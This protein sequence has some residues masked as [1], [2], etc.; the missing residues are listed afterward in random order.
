MAREAAR[1]SFRVPHA[2]P[3][4]GELAY[5][6]LPPCIV[7]SSPMMKSRV[8]I[9]NDSCLVADVLQ[10]SF[11]SFFLMLAFDIITSKFQK[12]ALNTAF[13]TRNLF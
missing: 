3:S 13:Q 1:I 8:I 6:L 10:L 4:N 2:D 9:Y 12:K 11:F 5:R 7:R